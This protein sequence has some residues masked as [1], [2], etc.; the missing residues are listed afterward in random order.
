MST[1]AVRLFSRTISRRQAFA[2]RS[3]TDRSLAVDK[4]AEDAEQLYDDSTSAYV[5]CSVHTN[6][7]ESAQE[8]GRQT[9]DGSVA[10]SRNYKQP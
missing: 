10:V 3:Q 5:P 1:L 7:L 9:H 2:A 6:K 4:F 8:F